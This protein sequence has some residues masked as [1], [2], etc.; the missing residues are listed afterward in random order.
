MIIEVFR[1]RFLEEAGLAQSVLKKGQDL[2]IV[3]TILKHWTEF[4]E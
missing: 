2:N 1:E 3:S 4:N